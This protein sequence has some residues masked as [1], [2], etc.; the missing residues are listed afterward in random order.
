MEKGKLSGRRYSFI[1]KY[2]GI[3]NFGPNFGWVEEVGKR[4][5]YCTVNYYSGL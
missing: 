5:R 4:N 2:S 3:R 1:T